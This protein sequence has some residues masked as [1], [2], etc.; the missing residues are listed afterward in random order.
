MSRIHKQVVSVQRNVGGSTS[1]SGFT[2]SSASAAA[3]ITKHSAMLLTSESAG[4]VTLAPVHYLSN[5]STLAGAT[6]NVASANSPLYVP[7]RLHSFTGLTGGS[8]TFLA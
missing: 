4:G 8:V 7:T 6:L 1:N 2:A 5:G 3:Q